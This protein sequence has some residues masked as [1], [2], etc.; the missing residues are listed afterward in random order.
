MLTAA[1]LAS[2][3]SVAGSDALPD[4]C[5]IVTRTLVSDG[6]GGH[7][8]TTSSAT[9]ACRLSP[10]GGGQEDTLGGR[11]TPVNR[12]VITVPY[13]ATVAQSAKVTFGARTFEVVSVDTDRTWDLCKRIRCVEVL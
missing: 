12:W 4:S 8:E 2:M 7:T 10:D 11:V 9:V 5:S 13:D 3:R 6:A 1:E